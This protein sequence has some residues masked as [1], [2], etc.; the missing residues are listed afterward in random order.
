[1]RDMNVSVK[2]DKAFPDSNKYKNGPKVDGLTS[3][4]R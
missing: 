1:M 2:Y 4:E 3:E